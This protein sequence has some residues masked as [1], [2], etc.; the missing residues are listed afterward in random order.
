LFPI[1]VEKKY[2]NNEIIFSEGASG[3]WIFI[4]LSGVVEISKNRKN[5]KLVLAKLEEG[6]ILGEL[7]FLG[8]QKRS[9]TARAVGKTRLGVIDRTFLDAEFNGL[10]NNFRG[11]IRSIAL[12]NYNLINHITDILQDKISVVPK[13]ISMVVKNPK[14][15]LKSY[16]Y[17]PDKGNLFIKTDNVLNTGD[18]IILNLSIP[19]LSRTIKMTGVVSWTRLESE[20]PSKLSSGMNIRIF[21]I[22]KMDERILLGFLNH[23]KGLPD[24]LSTGFTRETGTGI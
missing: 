13:Q 20:D 11:L 23:F 21:H 5:K 24:Y 12:R 9:A 10:S 1:A 4:I 17:G 7:S 19:A 14:K 22:D 18:K 16:Y 3:D 2:S 6:E 8:G 15:F